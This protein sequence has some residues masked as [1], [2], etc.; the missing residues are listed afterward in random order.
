MHLTWLNHGVNR[1]GR[2]FLVTIVLVTILFGYKHMWSLLFGYNKIDKKQKTG[3][4]DIVE[5]RGKQMWSLSY[6]TC[7]DIFLTITFEVMQK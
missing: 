5:S 3:A 4:L 7:N 2:F 1:Y 6:V